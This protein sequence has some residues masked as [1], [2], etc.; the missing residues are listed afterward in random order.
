MDR[1]KIGLIISLVVLIGAGAAYWW[2]FIRAEG[3][4]TVAAAVQTT[5]VRSG[6]IESRISGT[7]NIEPL[8]RETIKA[9]E[10]GEVAE[11][12]FHEGDKVKAGDILLRFEKDDV[13]DQIESMELELSNSRLE[14]QDLQNQYKRAEDDEARE[15][16]RL[17]IQRQ[18]LG[19]QQKEEELAELT[20]QEGKAP[21]TA[22]IDG[23][24]TSWDI[25]TGQTIT[26]QTNE[27]GEV[28]NYDQFQI[29]VAVD[30]LDISKV[31]IGQEA[32]I[33]VEAL[34]NHTYTGQ[35]MAIADE[36]TPSNGVSTFDVTVVLNEADGLKA[37]MSAE[38]SIQTAYKENALLLPIEAIQQAGDQYFV[39]VPAAEEAEEE[40]DGEVTPEIP[41]EGEMPEGMPQ[42][43][44][45]DMP[46]DRGSTRGNALAGGGSSVQM[47]S[48]VE[49]GIS[50]EDSIEIVSGLSEGDVVILPEVM[51]S[52]TNSSQEM[53]GTEGGFPGG[54][55]FPS[56]GSFPSGGGT[57]GFGGGRP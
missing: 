51:V 21:I 33:I 15:S 14:L 20:E 54:G 40:T 41:Q 34:S 36:G 25:E 50:N 19:I 2:F 8:S 29:V 39:L 7:G 48:F 46:A 53:R 47:R 52:S 1:K 4:Q 42:D 35:V 16:I 23:I 11:V 44:P 30:E 13:T 22:P 28:V 5:T 43:L 17:S 37:G 3:E 32:E 10:T 26:D 31:E 45:T 57:G 55:G 49:V 56:G 18:E 9:T 38:A 12:Y 6:T 24:L 27:L